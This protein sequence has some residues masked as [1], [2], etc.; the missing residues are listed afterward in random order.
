M[1]YTANEVLA[2]NNYYSP[3]HIGPDRGWRID[4][5]D[6]FQDASALVNPASLAAEPQAG[7]G[8]P[9]MVTE[10]HWVP[11]LG[12]QS[13]G[14]HDRRPPPPGG[15][16]FLKRTS[17]IKLKDVVIQSTNDYATVT[18]VSLDGIPLKES[19][20]V[21]VQVGTVAR[22]T[23]WVEREAT[24]QGDDGK[25]TF[26]GK[27]VVDTGKMPWAVAD[28]AI[29]LTIANPGLKTAT[30]LDVNGNPGRKLKATP[31]ANSLRLTLPRDAL[32]VMLEAK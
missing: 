2:V 26:A 1:E 21:L 10:S 32:Y 28:A 24:F 14:L 11:P 5:G 27:Q 16:G 3:V 19:K 7:A 8:H 9:M 25:E 22:P 20:R 30:Q 6:H 15:V 13:E 4:K 18:V 31:E 17:P 23:G 29:T 12:Y